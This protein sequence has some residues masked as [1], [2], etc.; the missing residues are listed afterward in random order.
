MKSICPG[1]KREVNYSL[2]PSSPRPDAEF[3]C[4]DCLS[5]DDQKAYDKFFGKPDCEPSMTIGIDFAVGESFSARRNIVFKADD[6]D[7]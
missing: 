6:A 2:I 5:E 7:V 1:C 3:C 4:Y